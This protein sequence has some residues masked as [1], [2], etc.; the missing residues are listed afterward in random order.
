[1]TFAATLTYQPV[2]FSRFFER[3]SRF[4]DSVGNLRGGGG[5]RKRLSSHIRSLDENSTARWGCIITAPG[6]TIPP[7]G[8][9]SR[10]MSLAVFPTSRRHSTA[11][12][13]FGTT[14]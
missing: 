2:P 11:I 14:Q 13:T 10:A 4:F 8:V 3:L 6:T 5:G 7:L 12:R 1:M 9:S